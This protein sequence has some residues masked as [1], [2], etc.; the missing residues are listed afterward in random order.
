MEF[1]FNHLDYIFFFY[2]LSFIILAVISCLLHKKKN[3]LVPWDMLAL[4][5]F[6]HGINEWVEMISL[7]LGEIPGF[8]YIKIAV[9]LVS[10]VFL[11]EFGRAGLKRFYPSLFG[12]L[13]IIWQYGLLLAVIFILNAGGLKNYDICV[14]YAFGLTGG[15]LAAFLMFKVF[16]VEKNSRYYFLVAA[17]VLGAYALATGIVVPA[18]QFY[19]A[20]YLNY[21]TFAQYALFPIQVL[22]AALIVMLSIIFWEYYCFSKKVLHN[23]LIEIKFGYGKWLT[24]AIIA[25]L[26]CGWLL[27][28]VISQN[29]D[30][31]Q[32]DELKTNVSAIAA[33]IDLNKLKRLKDAP[34]DMELPEYKVIRS[35]MQAFEGTMKGIRWLYLMK[36]KNG[37]TIFT[38]DSSPETEKDFTPPGVEWKTGE[39]DGPPKELFAVFKNG[40]AAVSG[41]YKDEWGYW[42]SA[43][44]PI[45]DTETR[46][47]HSVLGC[48]IEKTKWDQML[49]LTRLQPIIIT[50]LICIILIIAFLLHQSSLEASV[51]ISE[52]E[53]KYRSLFDSSS[54]SIFILGMD[55]RFLEVNKVAS[56]RLGYS[57]E[58][59]LKMCM[60]DI[61]SAEFEEFIPDRIMQIKNEGHAVFESSCL[62]K[63]K[64]LVP[65]EINASMIEYLGKPAVICIV[66][67][68]SDRK[69]IEG[70][71]K[72]SEL[73]YR[74]LFNEMLTGFA[75]H[76][77]ICDDNGNPC[78]YRFLEVNP[79][80]EKLTG[81]RAN[82][83]IGKTVLEILPGTES[84]WIRDF[85]NVAITGKPITLESYHRDLGKWYDVKAFSHEKGKFAVVFNDV[86]ERKFSEEILRLERDIV[87]AMSD[88]SSIKEAG[89]KV[90]EVMC[91]IDEVDSGGVYNL[92][93]FTGELDLVAHFGLTPEF[94]KKV[95]YY[96]TETYQARLVK[97]GR[98]LFDS[99]K[100]LVMHV[101]NSIED[102]GL[103]AIAV[104]PLICEGRPIA[105]IN[106]SSHRIEKF[107][108][109]ARKKIIVVLDK[110][111]PV[112]LRVRI[113]EALNEANLFNR[114][115]IS[116]AGEGIIVLDRDFRY[117]VWNHAMEKL[118]GIKSADV[119]GKNAFA[120]FPSLVEQ[121]VDAVLKRAMSGEVSYSNEF[122]LYDGKNGKTVFTRAVCVPHKNIKGEITG[123]I[124]VISDVTERKVYEDKMRKLSIAMEQSPALMLITDT[125]GNIEYVNPKFEA[126]TGYSFEDVRGK[127]P[128]ILKSGEMPAE[129][130]KEMWETIKAGKEW[131][132]QFHNRKKNG[133]YLWE[134]ATISPI[135]DDKGAV[136]HYIAI[137]EDITREKELQSQLLQSQKMESIGRLA[138]GIAHDFNNIIQVING[139]TEF[140][141]MKMDKNDS[142]RPELEEIG[143]AGKRA[144]EITNQ[145]LL[146]SRR[147]PANKQELNV[148]ELVMNMQKMFQFVLGENIRIENILFPAIS[149]IRADASQIEQSLMNLVVN[150]RDA[151]PSGGVLKFITSN[152]HLD[153]DDVASIT[154]AQPGCFVC[155]S[156][157]DTGEG[158][159][160]EVKEHLFE[161]FFTT[162]P[163][164]KGTGLGLSIV[165]GIVKQHNGWINVFSESGR[166]T[167]FEIYLPA[168]GA[169]EK[170]KAPRPTRTETKKFML[171][172]DGEKI[173]LVEDENSVRNLT[174]RILKDSNYIV[175]PAADAVEAIKIFN[176][177]KGGI[178][179]VLSDVVLPGQNGVALVEELIRRKSS[180]KILM[181]SGYSDERL[182]RQSIEEKGLR[183]LQKPYHYNQLLEAVKEILLKK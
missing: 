39:N 97:E 104:I 17:I 138:G 117:L 52:S 90:L 16:L 7:P 6:L 157:S 119:I 103:R 23:E 12:G 162:K 161:P 93:P 121:G 112:F 42:I 175:F 84:H 15:L 128:R 11:F 178:D 74:L 66:R 154:E 177:Q 116:H 131:R 41:P 166:G 13:N 145:L 89:R 143:K 67:D 123:I 37:K 21:A 43:F 179:L 73:K 151:M 150:A 81:L 20:R 147:K 95:S 79:A 51:I 86:T 80:Y 59:L 38:I 160:P 46:K 10:F 165:Y 152:I 4:F 174:T 120:L 5:G 18:D 156:V 181:A 111:A 102:E 49:Y 26:L 57:H 140:I 133:E 63:D 144:S 124:C 94:A 109:I 24:V 55:G 83:I 3:T 130:Y 75:L 139:F 88:V 33:G 72:D 100:Q 40:E 101:D 85:G 91:G 106:L 96:G 64:L 141:L 155:I 126:V 68:I 142:N 47:V 158:M 171:K 1:L 30:A 159:P 173:L 56:S 125:E 29:F 34:T 45:M 82:K 136:T 76:E 31:G 54:D 50:L 182:G 105:A 153:E 146:F 137:K 78:D 69:K 176:E 172:G 53:N 25:V 19:P 2:G 110:I 170:K 48:D 129:S 163:K 183:L 180:L 35:H 36:I 71:L 132:G 149:T 99:F 113:S 60:R 9:L 108:E 169:E 70:I 148:N 22:R 28:S 114:E 92:N 118:S 27:T 168:M 115:I 61:D 134:S 122:K 107:S 44:V 98:I 62:T 65:V 167:T 87:E 127:N 77:I 32:R 14:R 135:Y 58:E 164:G 8:N